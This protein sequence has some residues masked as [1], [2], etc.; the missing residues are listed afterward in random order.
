MP[1]GV[2]RA[3]FSQFT[4][5]GARWAKETNKETN[6]EPPG[7]IADHESQP[8]TDQLRFCAKGNSRVEL[9]TIGIVYSLYPP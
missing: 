7:A 2:R 3:P 8:S 9:A 6:P 5:L 4:T 1:A